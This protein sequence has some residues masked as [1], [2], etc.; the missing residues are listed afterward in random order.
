MLWNYQIADI[1]VI[2][3]LDDKKTPC[4]KSDFIINNFDSQTFIR[5]SQASSIW[6]TSGSSESDIVLWSS[7]L[8]T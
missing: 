2:D 3:H 6:Q 8:V 5:Q 1:Y 7:Q 4:P